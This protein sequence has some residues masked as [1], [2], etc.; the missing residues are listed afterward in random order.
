MERLDEFDS[1]IEER[2]FS[3][4]VSEEADEIAQS[5]EFKQLEFVYNLVFHGQKAYVAYQN[6]YNNDNFGTA[7]SGASR[8]LSNHRISRLIQLLRDAMMKHNLLTG[9]EKR[10]IL[11]E[12]AR[13]NMLEVVD[14][15]GEV[16]PEKAHLVKEHRVTYTKNG[17]RQVTV[18]LHDAQKAIEID[19]RMAGDNAAEVHRHELDI[20]EVLSR[21]RPTTGL[22]STQEKLASAKVIETAEGQSSDSE[23]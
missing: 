5:L 22:P 2:G 16:R 11:A 8:L 19:N 6:A 21:I 23:S 13:A 12:H 20:G 4:E 10:H 17:E 9:I 7:T 1:Q 18:K 14:E 3:L 15:L